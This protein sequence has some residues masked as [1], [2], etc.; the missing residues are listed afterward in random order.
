MRVVVGSLARLVTARGSGTSSYDFIRPMAGVGVHY[1]LCQRR[2][3]M[4]VANLFER[5]AVSGY[6]SFAV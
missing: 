6:H 5:L 4:K 2:F 1:E 3:A